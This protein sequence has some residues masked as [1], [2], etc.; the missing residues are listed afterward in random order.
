[1]LSTGE[2]PSR[3][4]LCDC[5]IFANLRIAFA[6]SSNRYPCSDIWN[7]DLTTLQTEPMIE[8][9]VLQQTVM[10]MKHQQLLQQQLME[11]RRDGDNSCKCVLQIILSRNNGD[12]RIKWDIY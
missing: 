7:V 11:V 6:S 1:M 10:Q 2:G 3:G 8:D 9:M 12:L 5:E 4:L